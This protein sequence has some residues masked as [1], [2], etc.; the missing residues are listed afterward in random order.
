M[1]NFDNASVYFNKWHKNILTTLAARRE[2]KQQQKKQFSGF[3]TLQ[4]DSKG[5]KKFMDNI[6]VIHNAVCKEP[7]SDVHKNFRLLF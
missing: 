1:Y 7:T 4:K 2:K 6:K 5:S 3:K